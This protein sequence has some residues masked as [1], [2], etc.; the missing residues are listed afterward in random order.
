MIAPPCHCDIFCRVVDNFGDA[1]VAWRLARQLVEERG[2]AARVVV[3]D[4]A[5]LRKI[6]PAV[7]ADESRQ[8]V[9]GVAITR[10][11]DEIEPFAP[12]E[13]VIEM[14]GCDLPSAY[15]DHMAKQSPR[16]V[17]LNVEY[18]SAEAWIDTHHLQPSPHPTLPLAKYFFFPGFSAASGGLIRERSI[19]T[20]APAR[21]EPRASPLRVMLFGYAEAP[22]E[23]LLAAIQRESI[24]TRVTAME[25]AL[26]G[27]LQR[28]RGVSATKSL[29]SAPALVFVVN[30]FV[31]Q[32]A[33]DTLLWQHDVLFV[34]GEDSFVRALWA[35]KPFI[36]QI[37]PQADGAHWAKLE[38][39][40]DRYCDGLGAGA[41]SALRALWHAWNAPD[42]D[43]IAPAWNA[44]SAELPAIKT[45]ARRWAQHLRN[46]PD[47]A[48]NILSFFQ[49]TYK[50]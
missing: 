44:F 16:P 17:W 43:A 5:A 3:N 42:A 45:H 12:A 41:A 20:S 29:E 7:T 32:Q 38:A 2:V 6:V 49:K 23:A 10:W 26:T 9:D 31:P 19:A 47:L 22:G 15:L 25:G 48:S 8:I 21:S 27:K 35:E 1:G 39:F 37:Y 4:L 46:Q 18:L 40:L 33:F 30:H 28:W 13:L 11:Q 24:P 14:F 36:W 50:I 34:R